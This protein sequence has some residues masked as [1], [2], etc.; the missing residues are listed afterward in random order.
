MSQHLLGLL[1]NYVC[2]PNWI[3]NTVTHSLSLS[4]LLQLIVY[5]IFPV[6]FLCLFS[7]FLFPTSCIKL[8]HCR[9][10]GVWPRWRQHLL[11]FLFLSPHHESL[12]P[13]NTNWLKINELELSSGS[14]LLYF[15]F[16]LSLPVYLT[17]PASKNF[18]L[19]TAEHTPPTLFIHLCLVTWP[20]MRIPV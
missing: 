14:F 13:Q 6:V 19:D 3:T 11:F 5:T 17:W 9:I 2:L 7:V 16:F 18:P 10:T 4:H 12:T 20:L 15:P 1:S 8:L